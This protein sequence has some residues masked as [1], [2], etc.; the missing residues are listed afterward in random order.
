MKILF[1]HQLFYDVYGG[2]SKYFAMMINSLPQGSWDTTTLLACNEYV[3]AMHLFRYFP[4][5]FRGQA[6]LLEHIN[7][8][9]TSHILSRQKFDVFHQTN[10]GTYY[11][12]SLGN[13]P[14]VITYHDANMSTYSPRPDIVELQNQSLRRADAIIAVSNNTKKD[15]L[16]LFPFVDEKKVHVI[17]HGIEKIH[18]KPQ[19][20]KDITNTPYILYV[21][22]R[23]EY[24]NFHRFI[25]AFAIL[26]KSHPNLRLICTSMPFTT[27]ELAKFKELEI[28]D[29]VI[30]VSASEELMKQLYAE[31]LF[32]IYPS[33]Y[34]GFGMPILEAWETR[35]PV[36]LSD[37]SCFPEIAGDAG[38]YFNPKDIDDMTAKI[39]LLTEDDNLRQQLISKGCSRVNLFTWQK[40][41]NEHYKI[42]ES[43]V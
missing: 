33:I 37:T 26:S 3:R 6:R 2:A 42:Y 31:A 36:C 32:F 27:T 30:H 35:C 14:L 23:A 41:A 29:K 10:F 4:K 19:H 24:K 16:T 28:E 43:L 38:L 20:I 7:R 40:C 9:Y 39:K 18:D 13:K 1:D 34:E 11:G 8:P 12:N 15:L 17:Y 22:L 21:G 25:K 5:Y